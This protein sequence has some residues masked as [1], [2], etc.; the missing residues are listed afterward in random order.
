M[1]LFADVQ[2]FL[3][4]H[5]GISPATRGKLLSM[6]SK[7]VELAVTIDA[8]AP[9]VKATYN[10]EGDGPLALTCYEAISA[11]NVAAR[12]AHYPNFEAVI[13][14]VASDSDMEEKLIQY[15]KS[16]V[17]PGVTYYFNQLATSMKGPLEAFK[18][19]RFFS[20]AKVQQIRPSVSA[21]DALSVFPFLLSQI[22][23]LKEEFPFYLAAS[24]DTDPSYDPLQFW[25][26]HEQ[27][28]PAWS[29]AA[30]HITLV[31]PSSAASERV[32]S[33]LRN[34][35]GERQNSSLQDY[36]KASIMMQYN[37]R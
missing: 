32:F 5:T 33:L 15:A 1:E 19:A 25:K 27:S 37:N 28:L 11:L 22:P 14:N 26:H 13:C 3:E 23:A 16:C 8:A 12:Q 20:P 10:L 24:E 7:K 17:Q 4:T 6:L 29:Q 21:L 2:P 9:F 35:F 36:I 30:R 31:Q 34:S 18:A